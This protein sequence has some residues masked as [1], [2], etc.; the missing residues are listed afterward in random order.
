[1]CVTENLVT[2][3]HANHNTE[4][5]KVLTSL[6]VIKFHYPVYRCL[7]VQSEKKYLSILVKMFTV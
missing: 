7:N 1:M 4:N 6:N 3:V 2:V 5:L